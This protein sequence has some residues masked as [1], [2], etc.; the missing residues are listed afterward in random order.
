VNGLFSFHFQLVADINVDTRR[1]VVEFKEPLFTQLLPHFDVVS[2][3]D[4][5]NSPCRL[6]DTLAAEV[7][8]V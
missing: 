2:C 4:L 1:N 5:G 8:G 6:T 3:V 7:Y